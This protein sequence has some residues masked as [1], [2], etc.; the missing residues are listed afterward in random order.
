MP[1]ADTLRELPSNRMIFDV[2]RDPAKFATFAADLERL[3]EEYGL[4]E[5]ERQ[6]F[7][8]VD[9][10]RLGELGMHPYFFLQILRLFG[11]GSPEVMQTY[12]ERLV[13]GDS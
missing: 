8:D 13:E 11:L 6:A 10:K 9:L 1:I 4:G 3:M 12:R 5:D 7:R 2:R